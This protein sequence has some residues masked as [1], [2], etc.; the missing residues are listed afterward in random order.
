M[1]R[2]GHN[3]NS[4]AVLTYLRAH[5]NMAIPYQEIHAAIG[6]QATYAVPNAVQH[7][8]GKGFPIERPMKGVVLYRET[9][10]AEIAPP[11][12]VSILEPGRQIF[13]QVG[14]SDGVIVVRGEDGELY[15]IR[16]L[17]GRNG[18]TA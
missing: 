4:T 6:A 7:L 16:P 12:P 1:I 9:P 2:K 18:G 11:A 17:F 5:P 13:E 3:G 8:M 10:H 14:Q 15:Y